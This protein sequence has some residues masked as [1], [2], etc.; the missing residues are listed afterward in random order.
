[1]CIIAVKKRGVTPTSE[2]YRSLIRAYNLRNKDGAG[3][4]LKKRDGRIYLSKGYFNIKEFFDS[5]KSHNIT[6]EDELL[7]HLRVV[8]AGEKSVENCH[9]F[10][11]S[12]QLDE[13]LTEEGW[14]NKPVMAHNGTIFKYKRHTSA[15]SDTINFIKEKAHSL[16]YLNA[17]ITLNKLETA[18]VNSIIENSRI[19]I[20]H[21]GKYSISLLGNWIHNEKTG[22]YYS[23]T[24]Y[25]GDKCPTHGKDIKVKSFGY[26]N[27]NRHASNLALEHGEWD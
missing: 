16:P 18:T 27:Y 3:F 4:A 19:A 26:P 20:M 12:K 23:N 13:L 25:L 22:I 21:P 2:F 17:L 9:P 6:K 11:C 7:V 1:M 8:S 15:Y 14:V 24:N 10:V 5:L